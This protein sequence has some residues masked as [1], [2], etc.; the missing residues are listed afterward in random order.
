M[1]NYKFDNENVDK[2]FGGLFHVKII[3]HIEV[4]I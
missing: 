2:S 1:P 3:F 4:I